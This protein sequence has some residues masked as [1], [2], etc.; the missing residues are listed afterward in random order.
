MG[1]GFLGR[2]GLKDFMAIVKNVISKKQDLLTFDPSPKENSKNPVTSGGVF[3]GLQRKSNPNLLDNWYF[4]NPI[5]QRMQ[6]MYTGSGYTIDRWR[7]TGN[8]SVSVQDGYV[9]IQKSN[10]SGNPGFLQPFDSDDLIGKTVTFSLLYRSTAS[11]KDLNSNYIPRSDDW[12]IYTCTYIDRKRS[13]GPYNN[14][15]MSYIQVMESNALDKY[16]DI[17]AIKLELGTEQTLAYKEGDEWVLN[18]PP[19]NYQQELAKCQK[20]QINLI[21]DGNNDYVFGGFGVAGG[22]T[23]ITCFAPTPVTMR[24]TPTV[25][26]SGDW[27]LTKNGD[28]VSG[29]PVTGMGANRRYNTTNMTTFG[30]TV[31]GGLTIGETYWLSGKNTTKSLILDANL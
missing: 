28:Y 4:A 27:V 15:S 23:V 12:T 1:K 19:P 25:T 2:D 30:V 24:A 21:R 22:A 18:D 9:R 31:E 7:S 14:Q 17:A 5:N 16:I 13:F 26:Y 11:V 20:Y 3:A 29:I 6:T 10:L 8:L